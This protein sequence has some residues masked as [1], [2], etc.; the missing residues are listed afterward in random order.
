LELR[1]CIA[2]CHR[3]HSK[4]HAIVKMRPIPHGTQSGYRLG[5]RCDDCRWANTVARRKYARNSRQ[6]SHASHCNPT[7][8]GLP[9]GVNVGQNQA[10]LV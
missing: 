2:M 7:P 1:K 4:F 9:G 10:P 8:P 6:K 5:C 3:C